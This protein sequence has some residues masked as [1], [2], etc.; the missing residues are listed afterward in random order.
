M[1]KSFNIQTSQSWENQF[2][3]TKKF[4]GIFFTARA[5]GYENLTWNVGQ[6][7]QINYHIFFSDN[8]GRS[9]K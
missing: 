8:L 5:Q 7:L 6:T 4:V 3:Q 9:K 2:N 1:I